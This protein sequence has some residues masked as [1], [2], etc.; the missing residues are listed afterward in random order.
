M[1]SIGNENKE[2]SVVIYKKIELKSYT[3]HKIRVKRF[4]KLFRN[5]SPDKSKIDFFNE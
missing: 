1:D 5:L 4:E 3:Q 2:H